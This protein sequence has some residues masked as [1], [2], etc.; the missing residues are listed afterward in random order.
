MGRLALKEDLTSTG[1][2]VLGGSSSW[3]AEDGRPFA[4]AEDKATCGNC[5]GLWPIIGSA[6]DCMEDGRAM[7]KDLDPVHCPCRQNFI[8]ASGN[9]PFLWS[10]GGGTTE[11]V[12]LSTP[13]Q[14]DDE[15]EHYFEIVDATNGVPI[16]GMTY[17]LLSDDISLADN[18]SLVSGKTMVV[19]KN[20]HPNL[21]FIAWREGN[22]R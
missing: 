11:I 21:T 17:K 3:F 2:R 18:Q 19:S 20:N 12:Q 5:K 22:V 16:E 6:R 9:S 7:V 4:L 1:G 8:Y 15:L 14:T 13:V 10:E